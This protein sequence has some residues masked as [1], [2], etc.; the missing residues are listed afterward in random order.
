MLSSETMCIESD[1]GIAP[2]WEE[3]EEF[4]STDLPFVVVVV[5][6]ALRTRLLS[7]SRRSLS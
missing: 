4:L 1:V 7:S 3:D 5:E 2:P 6:D